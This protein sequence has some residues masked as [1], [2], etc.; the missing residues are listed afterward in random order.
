[1][2]VF[3]EKRDYLIKTLQEMPFVF[4]GNQ[5]GTETVYFRMCWL[6]LLSLQLAF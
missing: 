5:L 6:T 1:M 2:L 3:D 4:A